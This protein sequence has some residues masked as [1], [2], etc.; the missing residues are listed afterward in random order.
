MELFERIRRD[1]REEGVSIR[2]LS[3]RHGVHRRTVRQALRSALP[4]PRQPCARAAPLLGPH[5]ET[6]REWLIADLNA[7]RKQRHRVRWTRTQTCGPASAGAAPVRRRAASPATRGC[8]GRSKPRARGPRRVAGVGKSLARRDLRPRRVRSGRSPRSRARLG[9]CGRTAALAAVARLRVSES[10]G[11]AT[12][13]LTPV[14]IARVYLC[15]VSSGSIECL[16]VRT[17]RQRRSAASCRRRAADHRK[18]DNKA[19]P[20]AR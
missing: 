11:A 1:Q 4:P 5:H 9:R 8:A 13:D 15:D 17:T 3:R 2:G 7:P 18:P 12:V 20:G 10:S 16:Q 14:W 19:C 6:I